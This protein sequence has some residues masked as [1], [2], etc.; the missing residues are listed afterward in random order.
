MR[1]HSQEQHRAAGPVVWHTSVAS[2]LTFC[3]LLMRLVSRFSFLRFFVSPPRGKLTMHGGESMP[4]NSII[5][6][7]PGDGNRH[8]RRR[9][10]RTCQPASSV[11]AN[12]KAVTRRFDRE[13]KPTEPSLNINIIEQELLSAASAVRRRREF[14]KRS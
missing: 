2:S 10:L 11:P 5:I 4:Y 3:R 1:R 8:H 6:A 14:T 9:P 13:D 7:G 12:V